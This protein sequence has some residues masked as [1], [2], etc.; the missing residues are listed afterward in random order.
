MPP[1]PRSTKPESPESPLD[2]TERSA[3]WT[4]THTEIEDEGSAGSSEVSFEAE[5]EASSAS[6]ASESGA[7]EERDFYGENEYPEEDEE[8][9]SPQA[10]AESTA[11]RRRGGTFIG[12][13]PPEEPEEDSSE[14]T[15]AGP[16]VKLEIISG[17]DEGEIKRFKGVRMVVGRVAGCDLVLTDQ[18]VSRRHLELIQGSRG[19]LLRDL[20][21]G[22]GTQVNGERV[23]E[24]VLKHGD[25]V[26]LGATTLRFV[27]ELIAVQIAKDE[28]DRLAA[29]EAERQAAEEQAAAEQAAAE[30]QAEEE[31]AQEAE[32]TDS[33]EPTSAIAR[34]VAGFFVGR[35]LIASI[36]V[37]VLLSGGLFFYLATRK[38]PPVGIDPK[39]AQARKKFGYAR[40]AFD[41]ERYE[42]AVML[43][44]QVE[45]LSPGLDSENLLSQARTEM[46]TIQCLETAQKLLAE[47]HFDDTRAELASCPDASPKRNQERA[48]IQEL[49]DAQQ[50]SAMESAFQ[51][52][53]AA[54]DFSAAEEIVTQLPPGRQPSFKLKLEERQSAV[55]SEKAAQIAH[56]RAIAEDKENQ[57]KAQRM[58]T[59]FGSVGRKL[60]EGAFERATLECDRVLDTYG[61]DPDVRERAK[62][63]KRLIPRFAVQ[64]SEGIRRG[65]DSPDTAYRPLL[66]ALALYQQIDLPGALDSEISAAL[67]VSAMAVAKAAWDRQDYGSVAAIYRGILERTPEDS[68]AKAGMERLES[69]AEDI[70]KMAYMVK[71]RDPKKAA[72][73]FK[74]ILAL[75][76]TSSPLYQKAKQQL[77]LVQI[78]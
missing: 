69:K 7:E 49:L 34:P 3:R 53:L 14:S 62:K 17:P 18:S 64:W 19:V 57:E 41:E 11:F 40:A 31:A 61:K 16:P 73:D 12:T 56:D 9:V 78:E 26:I 63:V 39:E 47:Q 22:N 37:G 10:A 32:A 13:P 71:D 51:K 36:A 27:D 52:A 50:Y 8:Y 48:R 46:K 77:K 25:E 67:N 58:E 30:A 1:R 42:D 74:S 23:T 15:R 2:R 29:E 55:A 45:R 5:E 75:V 54:N 68:A 21:S 6:G 33:R 44:E 60:N 20:E 70:F 43:L 76:P 24:R 66:D 28:A 35:R 4:E 59:A 38:A 72:E 65:Q